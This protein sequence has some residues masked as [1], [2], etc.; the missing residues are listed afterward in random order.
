ME[1][2]A[3][4]LTPEVPRTIARSIAIGN[5]AD[6][7]FAARAMIDS[8]GW[9]AHVSDEEIVAGIR[10]LAEATGVFTETAG[11]TTVAA[12]LKLARAGRLTEDDEVVLCITGNGLKTTDVLTRGAAEGAVGGRQGTGGCDAGRRAR[13]RQAVEI[14]NDEAVRRHHEYIGTAHRA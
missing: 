11:G 6:G 8:G 5:P 3:A 7:A 2:G 1:S 12:A 10:L 9:S 4:A 14:A 13:V